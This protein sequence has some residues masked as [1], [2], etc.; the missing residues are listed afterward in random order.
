MIKRTDSTEDWH[1]FDN[2]RGVVNGAD[3]YPLANLSYNESTAGVS[4]YIKF[5]PRG[6]EVDST[7]SPVGGN[8]GTYIYTA[9]RRGGHKQPDW[10]QKCFILTEN[11]QRLL[12]LLH[13]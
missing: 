5:T 12:T 13:S 10:Q 4:E 9:I 8:G 2:M 1:I 3:D 6:F 11:T 7:G